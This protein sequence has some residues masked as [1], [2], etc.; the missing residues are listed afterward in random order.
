MKRLL[1]VTL[2]SFACATTHVP[3]HAADASSP[4]EAIGDASVIVVAG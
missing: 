4:S 1:L 3:A 2:L